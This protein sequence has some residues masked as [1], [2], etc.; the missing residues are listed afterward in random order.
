MSRPPVGGRPLAIPHPAVGRALALAIGL[1]LGAPLLLTSPSAVAGPEVLREAYAPATWDTSF[2]NVYVNQEA[3]QSFIA[4]TDFLLTHLELFVFDMP[5][6]PPDF[7]QVSVA[8]DAGNHP[9]AILA[10]TA[11]QGS[12][13]W[14]WVP[15]SF[16][17]WVSLVAGRRYWIVAEDAEPRPK[18]YEWAMNSPGGYAG[19][20]AQW[21]D[22]ASNTWVNG[23]GADL[24]FKAFG[25]SGPSIALELTPTLLPVDPGTLVPID[26]HFNNSGNAPAQTARLEMHLDAALEYVG[27][28]ANAEG[29]VQVTPL[30]WLFNGVGTGPHR[31]TVRVLVEPNVSYYDG[32][33]LTARAYLN[34]TDASGQSQTTT[35]D[36]A[37]VSILVPVIRVQAQPN[38]RHVASGETFNVTASFFNVGSGRARYVWINATAGSS[39]TVLGDD[40]AAAGGTALGPMSWLFENVSAQAY[41]FNI[42]VRAAENL[43]PG[44]RLPFRINASYTDGQGHMFDSTSVVASATIHGPSFVVET[45]VGEPR[46]HPGDL[47]HVVVYVNN[48]G[49]ESASRIRLTNALPT[50][51]LVRDS[52]PIGGQRAGDVLTYDLSDVAPGPFAITL[53]FEVQGVAPPGAVLENVASLEVWNAT[54][55]ALRPSTATGQAVVVTPR[56]TLILSANVANVR[57]GDAIDLVLG[58][59]NTGNEA[60]PAVWLNFTLPDKTLL[61]NSSAPWV[62]SSGGTYSW[63]FTNVGSGM[64]TINVRLE[65]SARLNGEDGLLGLLELQYRRADGVAFSTNAATIAF[66]ALPETVAAGLEILL[67]WIAILI[68]LFLLFLL[69]GYMDLLPHRRSSIDD[70]FLLHNS[71][72]LICHYSTTLR[73]DVD[74]DIASGMLMA[75]RNFVADALRSK[76]GTLQELKYG[77]YRIQMAHGR[78]SILVVFTRG[79]SHKNLHV[80]MAEVLRNVE[81]AYEHVLESWSG[82]TEEFKG[83]E[84]HL[85][86]LIEA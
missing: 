73:P 77:D 29:G 6:P 50:W 28:D 60:A 84:E 41:V 30:T 59:N 56:F 85:L 20:E 48:T 8:E 53:T 55:V 83:V 14:T 81:M 32:Q 67:L 70:V 80:R 47:V 33:S 25:V 1:L 7:L 44:D 16:Y 26:V 79:G 64:R 68:A 39:L 10:G 17:P 3:A 27:D 15:F 22:S 37:A 24:F 31:V 65:V 76:N 42:T 72:I 82:R 78:H 21:F 11:Q 66:Q 40:G 86:K 23:T 52:Q 2:V 63:T 5:N 34:Y 19:G 54:D 43:L 71:G 62:A 13:N 45:F 61:V 57:P 49:D 35:T 9:G 4:R 38:P 58:W 18:G 75:V 36:V 69:L 46:P 74:S 12:Q 51:I